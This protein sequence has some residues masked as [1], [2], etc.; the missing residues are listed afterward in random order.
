DLEIVGGLLSS[1]LAVM[2]LIHYYNLNT[3]FRRELWEKKEFLN[4]IADLN[5][6]I[7]FAQDKEGRFTF[8]NYRVEELLGIKPEALIGK[9]FPNIFPE[10][11]QEEFRLAR[12]KAISKKTSVRQQ[13]HQVPGVNGK[14]RSFEWVLNP[15]ID[16]NGAVRGF[17]GAGADI[18]GDIE[19]E[20]II[21]GQMTDLHEKNRELEKYIESNLYLENFAYLASHD[22]KAPVRTIKSFSQLLLRRAGPK[23]SEDEKE[24][25]GF[26]TTASGNML[27]LVNDLLLYSRVNTQKINLSEIAIEEILEDIRREMA[28]LIN[29]SEA[30]LTI[31]P[32]PGE[33]VADPIKMRQL[34]QNLIANGIKF[35][36]PGEAPQIN[37]QC[38][39]KFGKYVFSVSDNGIG[40]EDAYLEKVFELFQR[41]HG[42]ES[43]EGSGIGLATCRK[44]VLQ[45][46]GSIW[47]T[48]SPGKGSTFFISLPKIERNPT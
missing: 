23:L 34:F 25:L 44:I 48:S 20:Q 33:I 42:P 9:S 43:Y 17:M 2:C 28:V 4:E 29:E 3:T 47:A 19:K 16:K 45:H 8:V 24:Y 7:L 21:Q 13:I 6:Y 39:E 30:Q 22:L 11:V 15:V 38:E 5:P 10:Q 46:G 32:M 18:T 40:I 37:V 35:S 14:L 12:E 41:L 27:R 1:I 31:G 36:R 26:I